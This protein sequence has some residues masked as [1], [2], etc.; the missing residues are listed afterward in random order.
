MEAPAGETVIVSMHNENIG[1]IPEIPYADRGPL[2]GYM[3]WLEYEGRK[4]ISH[5]RC[6]QDPRRHR[7]A[8]IRVVHVAMGDYARQYPGHPKA[9]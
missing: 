3:R 7:E 5:V 4:S 6:T 1:L 8:G 2:A 9:R